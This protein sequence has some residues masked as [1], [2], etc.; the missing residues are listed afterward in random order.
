MN[1]QALEID[2]AIEALQALKDKTRHSQCITIQRQLDSYEYERYI[3]AEAAKIT[4]DFMTRICT[5]AADLGNATIAEQSDIGEAFKCLMK[6]A[7]DD[8]FYSTDQWAE[9][10]RAEVEG[11]RGQAA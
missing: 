7:L 9:D 11:K 6:D 5:S 4:C 8:V 1:T 3:A 2:R 10:V